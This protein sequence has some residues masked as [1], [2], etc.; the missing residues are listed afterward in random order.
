MQF[1][2]SFLDDI[3]NRLP[4]SQ[5]VKRKVSLKAHGSYFQG[6]CPFHKEKTPSFSV[7]DDKRF[8]H[9]F[10]C[11][12]HGDAISFVMSTE[13]ISFTEAVKQLASIAGVALPEDDVKYKQQRINAAT[14]YDVMEVACNYYQKQLSNNNIA[15]EYLSSRGLREDSIQKFRIGYAPNKR[16]SLKN[17]LE[18]NGISFEKMS[19][20]GLLTTNTN[21]DSYDKFRDRIMFPIMNATGKVVAFGGRI[22]GDGKPK[23]LNSPE[24]ELFKKGDLLYNEHNAR[25]LAFKTG[26]IVVVEGYMD[27][28]ALDSFGIK[29]AISPLGTAITENQ[30]KILWNMSKEPVICL[31]GDIAGQGAMQRVANLCLPLLSPG[32]SLKFAFMPNGVD[33]DDYIKQ[34]GVKKIRQVLQNADP[35][36]EVIWSLESANINLKT[37]EKKAALE[38]KLKEIAGKIE[39]K[40]VSKY[41]YE[42]FNNKL[43][44]FFREQK[45]KE[46]KISGKGGKLTKIEELPD[47]NINTIEG[48]QLVFLLIILMCPDILKDHQ[49]YDEFINIHFSSVKL[50]KI[51]GAILELCEVKSE[52]NANDI[53]TYLENADMKPY[54]EYLDSIKSNIFLN[55]YLGIDKAHAA[56]SYYSC[57][58]QLLYMKQECQLKELEMTEESEQEVLIRR[59]EILKIEDKISQMEIDFSEQ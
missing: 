10:G 53:R 55:D 57:V 6:L 12:A 23:Y 44:N 47:F 20:L 5:V 1:S 25:K 50:D 16:D 30:L 28:I 56:W 3:R 40:T 54:I 33:P 22:L 8:Y 29:T 37:P 45:I 18:D 24:T 51:G 48:C 21:G 52:I 4:I 31:D 34:N 38:K 35:L 32:Y 59:R 9:C 43:W 46:S 7:N 42:F 26:K 58:L 2:Q 13:N 41:Y 11:G 19:D 17:H 49:I 39:N 14:L 36:S 15:L 27:V